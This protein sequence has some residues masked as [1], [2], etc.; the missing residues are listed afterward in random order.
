MRIIQ[1]FVTS[2]FLLFSPELI[3]VAQ[4]ISF[5]TSYKKGKT[6]SFRGKDFAVKNAIISHV[7]CFQTPPV[8]Y[9]LRTVLKNC[10]IHFVCDIISVNNYGNNFACKMITVTL[11]CNRFANN[12]MR[13]NCIPNLKKSFRM[14]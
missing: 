1:D 9:G 6:Q 8:T 3:F 2:L 11:A 10:G 14:F 7:K 13:N 12:K 4:Y 5:R